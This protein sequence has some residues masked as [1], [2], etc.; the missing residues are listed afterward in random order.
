[1]LKLSELIFRIKIFKKDIS[2][3]VFTINLMN[4][5]NYFYTKNMLNS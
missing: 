3:I 1:M 5:N 4:N 2:Q